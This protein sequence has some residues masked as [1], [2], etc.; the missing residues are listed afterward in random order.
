MHVYYFEFEQVEEKAVNQ[1]KL[2]FAAYNILFS[3]PSGDMKIRTS[4][5]C[6]VITTLSSILYPVLVPEATVIMNK[7]SCVLARGG[8]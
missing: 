2:C 7:R 6:T 5:T 3:A 8:P 4:D 1:L